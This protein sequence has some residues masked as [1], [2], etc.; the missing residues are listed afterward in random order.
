M[1]GK[2]ADL[3]LSWA[4]FKL[5]KIPYFESVSKYSCMARSLVS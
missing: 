2:I 1:S 3:S 4:S 5:D